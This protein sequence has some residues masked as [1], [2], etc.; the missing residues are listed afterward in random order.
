[1]L[2]FIVRNLSESVVNHVRREL[3]NTLVCLKKWIFED[4]MEFNGGQMMDLNEEPLFP[5]GVVKEERFEFDE[6]IWIII[7]F[8]L[9]QAIIDNIH[10]WIYLP[11]WLRGKGGCFLSVIISYFSAYSMNFNRRNEI[12]EERLLEE[13]GHGL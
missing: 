3:H 9:G 13:A 12:K 5:M 8:I 10:C 2:D 1:M 7:L 11:F 6:V 4:C